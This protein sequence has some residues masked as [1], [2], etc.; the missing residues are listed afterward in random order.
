MEKIFSRMETILRRQISRS[1][2]LKI[3]LG[4]LLYGISRHP[5]VTTALAKASPSGARPKKGIR[6]RH[7]LVIV[8]GND[9]YQNTVK[10]VGEMGGME[11]FVKK[12]QVVVIKPNMAWDRT[13]EQAANTNPQVVAALVDLCFKAGAKQVNVFDVCCNDDR[14]VY[15]QSGIAA[16]AREHR[17]NVFFASHW[18]VVGAHFPYDSPMEGWP[19]LRDAVMCDTFINVPVLKH[20]G[21][22]G[23]TLGMKNLMGVC[24]GKRG[25]M[26]LDLAK[27][28]ADLTDFINPELTVIDA[29]RVL[30]RNGPTGGNLEDVAVFN[31]VMAAA[32]PVLADAFAATLMRVDPLE[33]SYIAQAVKK[34]LGNH[35]ISKADILALKL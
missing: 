4:A 18:N 21:L 17:A 29:T 2:F 28:L 13:P 22:T 9:P 24:S 8:E 30:L 14:R 33:I 16:V 7:D 11:L 3:L 35:D 26:H 31:K 34:N 19:V 20:H 6:A 27:K 23:L 25:F 32:D 10:A 5:F 15:E 1:R 12:G